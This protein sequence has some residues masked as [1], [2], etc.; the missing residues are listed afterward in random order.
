MI[1]YHRTNT[2]AAGVI[3]R[4]GFRDR[5]G[6]YGT[7][8]RSAGVWFSD[9]PLDANEGAPGTVLLRVALRINRRE[10]DPHEWR[11]ASKPYREWQLP[12]E[13]VN[14]RAASVRVVHQ[15][16]EAGLPPPRRLRLRKAGA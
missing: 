2:A 9:E 4:R 6:I 12:A 16:Q 8:V 13:L 7:T 5:A 15:W 14:S 10:M 11:E 3:L 1:L